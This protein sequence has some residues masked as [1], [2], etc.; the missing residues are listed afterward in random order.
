TGRQHVSKPAVSPV[1]SVRPPPRIGSLQMQAPIMSP[2]PAAISKPTLLADLMT[3]LHAPAV[4]VDLSEPS[5]SAAAAA[6]AAASPTAGDEKLSPD[7]RFAVRMHSN[8]VETS[9]ATKLRNVSQLAPQGTVIPAVLETAIDSDL[10]GSVRAVV[11][12]DVRGF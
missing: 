8:A 1:I 4:V 12:R 7:E 3:R 11:S 10:P 6:T 2:P 9:H 5:A